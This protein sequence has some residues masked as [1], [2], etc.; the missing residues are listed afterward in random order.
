MYLWKD[1]FIVLIY[2]NTKN[3]RARF[4][5]AHACVYFLKYEQI[6]GTQI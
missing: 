5:M 6:P 3:Q 1:N 2:I 4:G